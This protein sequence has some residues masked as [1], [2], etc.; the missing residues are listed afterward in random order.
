MEVSS[1]E[2]NLFQWAITSM[3]MLTNQR[4]SGW[5]CLFLGIGFHTVSIHSLWWVLFQSLWFHPSLS[6]WD[7][8]QTYTLPLAAASTAL[9][10]QLD[11]TAGTPQ[12]NTCMI[13]AKRKT[14]T[15]YS[16]SARLSTYLPC[17]QCIYIYILYMLF[18][19][20]YLSCLIYSIYLIY[21]HLSISS[22]Y[23]PYLILCI[24]SILSE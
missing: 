7:F 15:T 3:A 22:N 12:W 18:F 20:S 4:V 2:N 24:L 19:L 14:E 6:C 9:C 23:L 5:I 16:L 11:S 8:H 21:P 1:W 13:L 10:C 17:Q